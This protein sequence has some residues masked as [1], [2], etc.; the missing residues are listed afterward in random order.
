MK[1]D[2][3]A[4]GEAI[5]DLVAREGL[6]LRGDIR[7]SALQSTGKGTQGWVSGKVYGIFKEQKGAS[8]A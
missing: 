3:A 6:C 8:V 7:L 4:V 2:W 5:N 1:T